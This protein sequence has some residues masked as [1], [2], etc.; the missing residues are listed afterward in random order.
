M[1]IEQI[2]SKLGLSDFSEDSKSRRKHPRHPGM[3]TEVSIH[4]QVY[5]VR[6]WSLGGVFF[7]TPPDAR[8]V[9]GDNVTLNLKFRLPHE[10]ITIRQMARVVRAAGRGIAAEF[11]GM[12][13]EIRKQF[14]K[15]IDSFH[16]QSFI[17]SQVA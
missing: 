6:D 13:P 5:S 8:M 12:P 2:L 7:D 14:E 16:A 11:T 15:V 17:E 3:Q 9:K 4:D 1:L 10:T